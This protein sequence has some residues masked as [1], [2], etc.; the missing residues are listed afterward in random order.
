M[1]KHSARKI[2]REETGGHMNYS[3]HELGKLE[4]AAHGRKHHSY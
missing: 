1:G 3:S 4:R 2:E